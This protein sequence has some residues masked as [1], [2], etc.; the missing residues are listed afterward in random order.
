[1]NKY[2]K[3][4]YQSFQGASDLNCSIFLP[5]WQIA[6]KVGQITFYVLRFPLYVQQRRLFYSKCEILCYNGTGSY[7]RNL[8][9]I[10]MLVLAAVGTKSHGDSGQPHF[11]IPTCVGYILHTE[12]L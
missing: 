8:A 4:P 10:A 6:A 11:I 2:K 12:V 1:M 7:A 9:E 3:L 5:I